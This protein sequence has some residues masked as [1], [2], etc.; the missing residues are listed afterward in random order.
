[1]EFVNLGHSGLKVSPM[2]LGVG[3]F[4]TGPNAATHEEEAHRIIHAYLDGGHNF[5]DTADGYE[6]GESEE[7][8]G[9]ALKGRRDRVIVATKGHMPTGPGPN[10]RGLSRAHLSNALEASLRRLGTDYVDLYQCHSEDPDTPIDETMATLD[11]FVKAGKVRY[12]GCSNFSGSKI[13]EAQWAASRTGGAR[14]V[15][16]QS[17]YSLVYR[18]IETDSL[19]TAYRHGLG[20]MAY[21][22]LAG[23]VLSGKYQRG[24][25]PP[26]DSRAMRVEGQ[27]EALQRFRR[28][29]TND[30]NMSIA[31]AVAGI[32]A[33]VGTT[34]VAVA[35]AWLRGRPG[36]TS[37]V[38][39]PRTFEQYEQYQE[40]VGF[41]IEA[42]HA[43]R[44]DEVTAIPVWATHRPGG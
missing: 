9:R 6:H 21:S 4:G 22:P 39:G 20:V 29:M 44:L 18:G 16:L 33:E 8:L 25:E 41:A 37:L 10:D 24:A 3:I 11:G 34:S 5:I 23:G 1:V 30:R 13:V 14:F 26:S 7:V 27:P 32:A 40:A 2:C 43:Q 15:S 19:P 38:I 42:E 12:I 36:V 35:L 17:R 28:D 31:E